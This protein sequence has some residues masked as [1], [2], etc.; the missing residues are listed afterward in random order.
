MREYNTP[1]AAY[2]SQNHRGDVDDEVVGL[3]EP[4]SG[5]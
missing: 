4:L 1:R 5:E 2:P 3:V